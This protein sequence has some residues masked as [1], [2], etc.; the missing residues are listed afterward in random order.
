MGGYGSHGQGEKTGERD[1]GAV[2]DQHYVDLSLKSLFISKLGI[3]TP[4]YSLT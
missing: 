1:E 3:N 4:Y 2:V